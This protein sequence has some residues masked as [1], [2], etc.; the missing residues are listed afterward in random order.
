MPG[1]V[2]GEPQVYLSPPPA[3][4]RCLHK[5]VQFAGAQAP[6][7]AAADIGVTFIHGLY[8]DNFGL[9]LE[10][11]PQSGVVDLNGDKCPGSQRRLGLEANAVLG[12]VYRRCFNERRQ[13]ELVGL[14]VEFRPK[15]ATAKSTPVLGYALDRPRVRLGCVLALKVLDRH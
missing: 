5:L 13:A 6:S 15:G 11:F 1:L 10:L 4:T 9:H 12:D 7:P 2:R 8:P 3:S 14:E